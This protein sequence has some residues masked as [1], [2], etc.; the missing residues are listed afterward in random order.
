MSLAAS[1]ETVALVIATSSESREF[2]ASTASA[3]TV[4]KTMIDAGAMVPHIRRK[5]L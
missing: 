2:G 3:A 1:K 4:K 5:R